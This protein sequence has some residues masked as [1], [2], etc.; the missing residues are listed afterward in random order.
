[1]TTQ[2]QIELNNLMVDL[3]IQKSFAEAFCPVQ[4]QP[5]TNQINK[6]RNEIKNQTPEGSSS[7]RH[8]GNRIRQVES[9]C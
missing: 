3:L 6:I 9:G 8:S 1:M 7:E 4:V 5:L 2:T